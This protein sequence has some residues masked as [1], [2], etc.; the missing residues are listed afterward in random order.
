MT[1]T[2]QSDQPAQ[3]GPQGQDGGQP[4]RLVYA[5]VQT[6]LQQSSLTAIAQHMFCLMLRNMSSDGFVF[7]DPLA[8]Q[9]FSPGTFSAPGCIIAAPSFPA[10][11]GTVNQDYV[12]NWTRD[13]AV[14]AVEIAAANMPTR[15]GEGVQP[16]IDYVNFAQTCQNNSGSVHDR[17]CDLHRRG[18]AVPAV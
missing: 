16:L 8:G 3:A 17:P 10:D 1:V 5:R 4:G 6:A 14:T 2:A 11:L 13:A 15:P 18:P 12:F 9:P 7:A